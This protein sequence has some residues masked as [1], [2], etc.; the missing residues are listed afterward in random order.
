MKTTISCVIV[1]SPSKC[2]TIEKYL[3]SG[4]KCIAS[5]GHLRELPSLKCID[6]VNGYAQT[7]SIIDKRKKQLDYMRAEIQSADEVIL[8]TDDDREGEAIAWHI[9]QVFNLNIDKTKRIIFHEITE[10]ALQNAIRNPTRINMNIVSAQQSRQILDLLVGF[11]VSPMLWKYISK[12]SETALSAGR[13]QTPALRI[14]YD[15]YVNISK[16]KP[17]QVY[18]TVGYFT[19]HS[20]PFVL[21]RQ[22]ENATDFL[23]GSSSFE[24]TYTCSSPVKVLKPPPE[25]L[26]TSKLQQEASNLFRYSPNETMKI[27]QTLYEGG[28]ITY[29]RTDSKKYS[30]VF[31]EGIKKY[32]TGLYG[33]NFVGESI[34][35]LASL[36]EQEAHEAIRPT[37]VSLLMLPEEYGSK[38]KKL[39][40]LIR[41]TALESCM[42]SAIFYTVTA[43][44]AAFNNARFEHSSET[45]DFAGWK[46]VNEKQIKICKEFQYLQTIQPSCVLPYKKMISSVTII[47]TKQHYSEAMLVRLLEEKGIGRPSTFSMLVDKI[48]ERGYVK[49]EDIKG[50]SVNCTDYELTDGNIFAIEQK[51][52][53][54]AERGKLVIQNLGILIIEFLVAHFDD[55]FNYDYTRSIEEELDKISRGDKL[56]PV[57]CGECD[58][59]LNKLIGCLSDANKLEIKIDSNNAYV[60]GKHGPVIKCTEM[61][62]DKQVVTFKNVRNDVNVQDIERGDYT[63][64]ELVAEKQSLIIGKYQN[65]DVIIR[66]GKFGMYITWGK[67][68]KSV[69]EL[70]NRPIENIRFEEIEK[71]LTEGSNIIREISNSITIR[72]GPK[73][74]YVFYKLP[75]MTKPSFYKLDGFSKDYKLCD[76][77]ILKSWLK[78]TYKIY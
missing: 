56:L 1:E 35:L 18:N 24:H 52:E 5:C 8:A 11:K 70:G 44:I 21:N 28:F 57:V 78:D 10:P 67:N 12:N 33:A 4:Y 27:C 6:V 14:I 58:A 16:S 25:P 29:M 51:R 72:K 53:F 49:K 65:E 45:I 73:G 69:K 23:H 68:S 39:Y 3:G 9:C 77:A 15:N 55:L 61:V 59:K 13:C 46:I 20:I 64:E 41:E 38:E 2:K 66:N 7:Y 74:D 63:V 36:S 62:N 54:G 47:D 32:I 71:Y 19:N 76:I 17:K 75:K 34:D 60:I 26:T 42:A 30:A 48:Q 40:K 22:L 31:I 50:T 43:Q 37:D